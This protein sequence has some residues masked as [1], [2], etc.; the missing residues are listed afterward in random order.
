MNENDIVKNKKSGNEYVVKQHNPETQDLITKDA[1]EEDIANIKSKDN[2]LVKISELGGDS[3]SR[4]EHI[5]NGFVRGAAPGNPGSMYNE[6]MSGE[7][8][9]FIRSS[10]NKSEQDLVR[11]LITTYGNSNLAKQNLSNKTAGGLKA[12]DFAEYKDLLGDKNSNR[13]LV[14]KSILAVRSGMRKYNRAVLAT[15]NLG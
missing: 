10:H 6:I 13:E 7:V 4:L 1:S 3:K 5:K 9:N 11:K 14:S 12:A 2:D 15:N 8:A